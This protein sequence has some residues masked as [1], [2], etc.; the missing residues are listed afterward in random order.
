[1]TTERDSVVLLNGF[2]GIDKLAIAR[3]L[4]AVLNETG[5]RTRLIDNHLLIDP[6]TAIVPSRNAS[7]HILRKELRGVAFTAIARELTCDPASRSS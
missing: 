4:Q 6:A 2:P 1:M 7:H 3:A 5:R